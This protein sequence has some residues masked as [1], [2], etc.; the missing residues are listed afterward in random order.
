MLQVHVEEAVASTTDS[1]AA[2]IQSQ[3]QQAGIT[4]GSVS[5]PDPAHPEVIQIQARACRPCRRYSYDAQ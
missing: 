4:V 5:R 3:L 1:D 2:R